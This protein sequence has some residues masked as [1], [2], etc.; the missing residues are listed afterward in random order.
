MTQ[1]TYQLSSPMT[2]RNW[3]IVAGIELIGLIVLALGLVLQRPYLFIPGV[4]IIVGASVLL[5]FT[6]MVRARV[7]TAVKLTDDDI[8]IT[9]GGKSATAPWSR[10]S[11]AA[12]SGQTIYL[13]R[14]DRQPALKIDSPRGEGDPMLQELSVELAGRLDRSRGY[15]DL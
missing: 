6:I 11:D 5:S 3:L 15:R 14:N 2:T 12:I 1:K 7:A 4:V 8:T 10:I 9:S 13:N